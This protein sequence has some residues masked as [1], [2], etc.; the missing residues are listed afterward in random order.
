MKKTW[1]W[2]GFLLSLMFLGIN[3]AHASILQKEEIPNYYY[4]RRGG[5]EGYFS[6]I[7]NTYEIDNLTTYCIEPGTH[8]TTNSY[9]EEI[10]LENSPYSKEINEKMELIGYYGYDY[11]THHTLRYRLATQALIWETAGNSI[12][13]FWTEISGGGSYINLDK[14]K[15]EIMDLVNNHYIEPSFKDKKITIHLGDAYTLSDKNKVLSNYEVIASDGIDY[16]IN[17]NNIN[18]M[19]TKS[20]NLTLT[21]QKKSYTTNKTTIFKGIDDLSQ[22]MGYFSMSDKMAFNLYV[23]VVSGHVKVTKKDQDTLSLKPEGDAILE[24]A[25]YGIY[26]EFN[27]LVEKITI[28]KDSTAI[29]NDLKLG[30]YYLQEIKAPNGYN[31]NPEKYYFTISIDDSEKEVVVYDDVIKRDVEIYK[32]FL[33][34]KTDILK[35][36]ANV[37]FEFYLKSNNSLITSATTNDD[38]YLK[39]TLP[40]GT[41]IVKQKNSA[42]GYE[43]IPDFEITVSENSPDIIKKVI[44][45]KKMLGKITIY[46]YGEELVSE[47]NAFYFQEIKLNDVSFQLYANEDIYDAD[48]LIYQKDAL[49][50]TFT[51]KDGYFIIDNLNLGTY[52]IIETKTTG[53]HLLDNT[54]YY[55]TINEDNVY[56]DL[57]LTLKNYLPKGHLNITKI[58]SLTG[59]LLPNTK[60]QIYTEDDILIFE[61]ITNEF[62]NITIANLLEGNY[63]LVE[64]EAPEGY[65]INQEKIFFAIKNN[66]E[67]NLTLENEKEVFEIPKT[68]E[69]TIT[70][71]NLTGIISLLLEGIIVYDK[72]ISFK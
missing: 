48:E 15:K 45:D 26:D 61:G 13:E 16:N 42:H 38:G 31:L 22:K 66:E 18:M 10:G 47:D 69:N 34:D 49:I 28:G 72:K 52:Y 44:A 37:T 68:S 51:T 12:V 40:Y 5:D 41:Y 8:I 2:S 36:E 14:E 67:T 50:G 7:Y 54:K 53:N 3:V 1:K 43:K 27:R 64:A 30:N 32:V 29:S 19:P 23:N 6:A 17:G 9:I 46:K 24:G 58:D 35:S 55:F 60:I 57:S 11:P 25:I 59:E 33:K 65:I 63:Y 70:Y 21:L 62:G 20:G 71:M 39:V 4:T 56:D